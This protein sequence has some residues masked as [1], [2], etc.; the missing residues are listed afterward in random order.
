MEVQDES[1]GQTPQ[2]PHTLKQTIRDEIVEETF[3]R[4]WLYV[5]LVDTDFKSWDDEQEYLRAGGAV[6]A[7]LQLARKQGL[8]EDVRGA[9]KEGCGRLREHMLGRQYDGPSRLEELK[10]EISCIEQ[11]VPMNEYGPDSAERERRGYYELRTE[12]LAIEG[13]LEIAELAIR[14]LDGEDIG[15]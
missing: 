15:L 4:E 3:R 7:L 8:E 11:E 5:G 1:K 12:K 9:E 13:D 2:A 10:R 14:Y 6:D